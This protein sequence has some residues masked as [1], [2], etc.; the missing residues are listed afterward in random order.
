MEFKASHRHAPMSARKAR[1]VIDLVRGLPVNKALDTLGTTHRRAAAMIDKVIRSAVANAEHE[2]ALSANELFVKTAL[3]NEGPLKQGRLRW[4]PGAM[5][6]M[7]PFR[8]RT[9][10]IHVTLGV[11]EGKSKPARAKAD[12]A[13]AEDKD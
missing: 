11:V 3:I 7:N 6:R 12:K 2:K 8:K 13:S 4:R 10:H 1:L 9:S 5:G